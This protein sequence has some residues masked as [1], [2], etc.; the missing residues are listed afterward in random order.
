MNIKFVVLTCDMYLETRVIA[1]RESFLYKQ[2]R[3]FLTDSSEYNSDDVI[4]YD[5]PK[6]YEGIQDKYISFFKNYNFD[7]DYYFFIDD[8]TF[9]NLNNLNSLELMGPESLFCLHRLCYLDEYARDYN[10]NYT[11]YPLYK[12]VGKNTQLPLTYPSGGSGFILSKSAVLG[13]QKFL[14]NTEYSEIPKSL[15]SDVSVGFWMRSCGVQLLQTNVFWF[16]IPDRLYNHEIVEFN[17]QDEQQAVTFH[18]VSV[19]NMYKFNELYN[20]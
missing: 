10:G 18:Y 7:A 17:N 9:V 6:N 2:N 12:I 8:D 5:T 19:E 3:I 20:R 14:L 16:D 1:Q 11:G 13:I 4:G 15:H